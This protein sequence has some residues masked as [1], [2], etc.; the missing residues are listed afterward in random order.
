MNRKIFIF[1]IMGV[2]TLVL[3][4]SAIL[5]YYGR[6][7]QHL[8]VEQS[9][10]LTGNNCDENN[11]CTEELGIVYSPDT[12]T[13][14]LY[15]LTNHDP[16]NIRSVNLVRTWCGVNGCGGITTTYSGDATPYSY[17]HTIA[18]VDVK[19]EDT[20]DGWLQW[21]YTGDEN[22][23]PQP[24]MTVAINYPYGFAITT[25]DDGSH[26]GWYYAPDPDTEA[27]RVKFADYSG[28]SYEDWVETSVD[29][30]AHTMTVRVKKSA[31]P[32][33][34]HWHGYANYYNAQDWINA[35]GTGTGYGEPPFEV[36]L[37]EEITN[38]TLSPLES[39]DLCI[40]NDVFSTSGEYVITTEA[41]PVI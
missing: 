6:I 15:T 31:L 26:D 24:K 10:V 34:F 32:D 37:R 33:T 38:V 35:D 4:S 20:G 39:L 25:F 3:V 30:E 13:D 2:L 18:D 1:A 16:E 23:R 41:Q 7:N 12:I 5:T 36:T 29:L 21:T 9:V 11:V 14:C 40:K 8:N 28:G 17:D 27:S 19:V 22:T